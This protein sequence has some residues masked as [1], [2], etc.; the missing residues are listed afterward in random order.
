VTAVGAVVDNQALTLALTL[1][2]TEVCIM[3]CRMRPPWCLCTAMVHA[4]TTGGGTDLLIWGG[5]PG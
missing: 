4:P 5:L 2:L 1:A 3:L